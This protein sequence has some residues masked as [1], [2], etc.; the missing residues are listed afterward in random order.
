MYGFGGQWRWTHR[1]LQVIWLLLFAAAPPTALGYFLGDTKAILNGCEDHWT[2]QDRAAMPLLFQMTVCVDIRVVVPGP[3]VAFSYSSVHAPRPELG[4]EGDDGALYGWLLRV[5]HRFPLQLSPTH[6]HRVCLRRDVPRNSFSLEVDGKM[7]A[8]RTVIAQAIPPY[9]SLWLGCRPRDRPPGATLG[10]VE[11]YLFRMWED[12]G[13][14]GLCEDGTV[15]GWNAQYWGL[16]SPNARQRDPHLLCALRRVRRRAPTPRKTPKGVFSATTTPFARSNPSPSA[17][18]ADQ[19]ASGKALTGSQ[20]V[21]CSISQLCSDKDAYFWMLLRVVVQVDQIITKDVEHLVSDAFDCKN[22]S[23]DFG[24]VCQDGKNVQVEEVS[25]HDKDNS[26]NKTCSVVLKLSRA[27]SACELQHASVSALQQAGHKKIQAQ[28]I[29][30]VERVARNQCKDLKSSGEKF[31]RCTITSSLEDVCR[32]KPLPELPCAVMKL[33]SPDL[34]PQPRTGSCSR[35][36]PRFCDCTAS[37]N[38]SRQFFAIRINVNVASVDVNFLKQL[39]S[40]LCEAHNCNMGIG[41]SCEDCSK[42]YRW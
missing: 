36:K 20:F 17:F 3:W 24:D 28:I 4:L 8:E 10:K 34:A 19:T 9:G 37:C 38:S 30:E 22:K 33:K 42:H 29:G 18:T 40:G 7:V 25:C 39:L 6:W 11:L 23:S 2:L 5:R 41:S 14:H 12:L 35:E 1:F 16:T 13:N 21:N 15:I 26:R 31:M 32:S 27:V